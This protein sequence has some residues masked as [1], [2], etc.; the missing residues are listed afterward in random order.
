MMELWHDVCI[1]GW[2]RGEEE[3][4]QRVGAEE[5]ATYCAYKDLVRAW[6]E[7]CAGNIGGK[8][9]AAG[10]GVSYCGIL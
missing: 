8:V 7:I 6:V 1:C 9:V 10:A 3:I 2:E 4:S 5:G